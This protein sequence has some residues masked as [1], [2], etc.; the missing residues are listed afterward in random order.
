MILNL[1]TEKITF[2]NYKEIVYKINQFQREA[3]NVYRETPLEHIDNIIYARRS[4]TIEEI[5]SC[6]IYIEEDGFLRWL[7]REAISNLHFNS[8]G[9]Y[10]RRGCK[11]TV[12]ENEVFMLRPPLYNKTDCTCGLTDKEGNCTN[13]YK[14]IN[15]SLNFHAIR[16]YSSSDRV[17]NF[18]FKPTNLKIS[19]K[20]YAFKNTY[21]NQQIDLV[22]LDA[23][24]DF[25]RRSMYSEEE[26]PTW[27]R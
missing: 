23:V 7:F 20:G 8:N 6:K 14:N 16:C 15:N 19:W 21:S 26:L 12:Y 9:E 18:W 1:D 27:I 11:E 22:Y 5:E 17:V 3:F 25:C 4:N 10:R 13:S 2:E 24:L